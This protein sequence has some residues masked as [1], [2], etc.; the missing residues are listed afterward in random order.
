MAD[1]PTQG[2]AAKGSADAAAKAVGDIQQNALESLNW[3]G[4]A[5][6]ETWSAMGSEVS[7]FIAERIQE[8]IKT[9]HAMLKCK[10]PAEL[11]AIQTAFVQKAIEQYTEETGKLVS[12][13]QN[14][15]DRVSKA[16]PS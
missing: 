3:F 14:F 10:N 4:S 7:E 8:D 9:Q 12:L 13:Q 5:W 15:L 2:T 1:K 16:K 11:S 6:L